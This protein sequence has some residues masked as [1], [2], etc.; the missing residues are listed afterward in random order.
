MK[1]ISIVICLVLTFVAV[2][3]L[4]YLNSNDFL[5][6]EI[7]KLYRSN[8]YN[9]VNELYGEFFDSKDYR[10]ILIDVYG[11]SYE[12]YL[13]SYE[14]KYLVSL[15]AVNDTDEFVDNFKKFIKELDYV[16]TIYFIQL[17]YDTINIDTNQNDKLHKSIV[18]LLNE[19]ER[20]FEDLNSSSYYTSMLCFL[21]FSI[22]NDTKSEKLIQKL[23]L[24]LDDEFEGFWDDECLKHCG[25][26]LLNKNYDRFNTV[27]INA[28]NKEFSSTKSIAIMINKLNCDNEQLQ[29]LS[30]ALKDVSN[31]QE[32]DNRKE[33]FKMLSDLVKTGDGDQSGDGSGP[34]RG[35]FCD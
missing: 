7:D 16:K 10:Q 29:V 33:A 2:I 11:D 21:N 14:T 25:S 18:E 12:D 20:K 4:S 3:S 17:F 30:K 19:T 6:S 13:L 32:K 31:T 27:F 15:I 1:K 23:K 34:I 35:R 28:Y 26:L 24:E 8:D 5:V 9:E 22:G